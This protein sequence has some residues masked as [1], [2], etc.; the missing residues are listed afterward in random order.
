MS[1]SKL[2][3][4][5]KNTDA[6]ATEQGFHYQ[7]LK[8][9]KTWLENRISETDERIYCDN[10]EDIFQRNI[11]T[12]ESK[13]RQVKLYSSNFSFSREEIQKSLAHFF[14]LFVKGDYLQDEVSFLFETNSDIARET[15]GND[16][17]LLN[18]W[19]QNQ[20]AMSDDLLARVTVR[21]KD[22][23]DAYIAEVYQEE[24]N[25]DL[26]SQLQQ[27]KQI[28]DT[29]PDEVWKK[30]IKSIK[31]QFDNIEPKEAIP[32]LIA[33][34]EAL[35]EKLPIKTGRPSTC[36]SI[37]HWE[38]A[39]KTAETDAENK[40]VTNDLLDVLLLNDGTDKD[41][42]YAEVY[43]KWLPVTGIE[44]FNIGAFYE[45]I[46]AARHCRWELYESQHA[47]LWLRI[48]MLYI[49]HPD[50]LI[51]CKRKAIYE[52]LFLLLSPDP[53]TGRPKGTIAGQQELIHYYFENAEHRN[54]LSDLEEDITFL[55]LVQTHQMLHADFLEEEKIQEWAKTLE[56]TI[57]N[58]LTHA[59]N[60]DEKCLAFELK[61]YFLSTHN[62]TSP[63]KQRIDFSI[64]SY[65]QII[66]LLP[67]VNTYS[68]SRLSD[69]LSQI[70]KMLIIH[71]A[72]EQAIEAIEKF[73]FEIEEAATKTGRQHDAAH[74]L[75]ERGAIYLS[76]PNAKNFL[77]GL[78]AFHKAKK[79]W[80][81]DE[82]K[83]GFI[84]ALL[85]ISQI[86]SGLGMNLAAKY[87]GL[88]AVWASVNYG[89]H[90]VF[91]RVSDGFA[92]VFLADFKQ[93]A[94]I[95][96]LDDY[97]EY[98][99]AR[100]EF[101]PEK[102]DFDTDEQFKKTSL[103]LSA[104][105]AASPVL[106]PDLSV[107]IEFYKQRLT[108]VYTDY[109]QGWVEEFTVRFQDEENLKAFLGY[110]LT[111]NPLN[112]VGTKRTLTFKTFGIEWDLTF[113]NTAVGNAIGEEFC[114]LLQVTLS[115]IGLLG[116]DLHLLQMPVR[117][118]IELGTDYSKYL[119]QRPSHEDT[120]YDL[121]IPPM[122]SKDQ[123]E[124]QFHYGFLAANVKLLL[125][126]LSL[127][128]GD[129]FDAAFD[130]LY[131]E[132]MLGEK[133]LII[134]TYQKV[135]FN[136][137]SAEKFDSTRRA[138]F[139]VPA[140]IDFELNI[141]DVLPSFKDLSEK[142]DPA[143]SKKKIEER[144]E[145]TARQLQVTLSKWLQE[146]DFKRDI[147]KFREQGWLDW[148]ILMALSNY[149]LNRKARINLEDSGLKSEDPEKD[150]KNEFIRLTDLPEE[151]CYIEVP[152][153]SITSKDFLF[154]LTKMPVDTLKTFGLN[155]NTRFPN[156]GAIHRYMNKRFLF[157]KDDSPD[158]NPLKDI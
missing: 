14:M 150:F 112:D 85:N 59:R 3:L 19:H 86:Y 148:Q 10:E 25:S 76:K 12:G 2:F 107:F 67:D 39:K 97:W 116:V 121:S 117:L 16:G 140:K 58:Q 154:H 70:L 50:S 43:Q 71:D 55:Q 32:L 61:G 118:E 17:D 137:Q 135:Y 21:V 77:K 7:K 115:E 6:P 156:F 30:F 92:M 82:T 96:A 20:D 35:T 136:F 120:I 29:L 37:L 130:K 60:A 128:P 73:L 83:D 80:H 123:K 24:M 22:I 51:V 9:L 153:S 119:D 110:A 72:D 46:N 141:R 124:I 114:A 48:L 126:D 94:W 127:L 1:I 15:R 101:R 100:L 40:Y 157:N 54:S 63:L 69:L 142:Y 143:F 105:L 8:T 151:D 139:S 125:K 66:P 44:V 41:R 18:E 47:D 68:I 75:V 95:S 84:L 106:H 57:D 90:E 138:N 134:N 81:L 131:I 42:W 144:Y 52:Y 88:C 27:A 4:F 74:S 23:I 5:S 102:L 145:N 31:W 152:L 103:D 26:K 93:G 49:D 89:N 38:I 28:Y 34:T 132:Q 56:T 146:P 87:Y 65:Q 13:F 113:E 147:Q 111:S 109:L 36:V 45:V 91:K 78:E 158:N 98:I 33:E 53:A 133:G 62:P 104:L 155:N 108:W 149:V 122:D 11:A 129:Q 64:A 79:L 99:Q